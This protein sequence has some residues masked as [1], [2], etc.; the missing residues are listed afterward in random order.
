MKAYPDIAFGP[1]VAEEEWVYLAEHWLGSVA[2]IIVG[3][4]QNLLDNCW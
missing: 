4:E 3:D 2:L 1:V